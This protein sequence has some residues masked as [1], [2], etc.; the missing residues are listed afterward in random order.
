MECL[1]VEKVRQK[2]FVLFCF[3]FFFFFF[4]LIFCCELSSNVGS[5]VASS[6]GLKWSM[7]LMCFS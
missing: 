3:F 7:F 4:F 5:C 1:V 6:F 2:D